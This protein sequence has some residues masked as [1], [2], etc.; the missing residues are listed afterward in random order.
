[1]SHPRH[2]EVVVLLALTAAI[3]CKPKAAASLHGSAHGAAVEAPKAIPSFNG[4]F[5]PMACDFAGPQTPRDVSGPDGSNSYKVEGLQ[6][7]T[8]TEGMRVCNV[9][10]HRFAEHR[11]QG[12]YD[13]DKGRDGWACRSADASSG[14]L[15]AAP[16]E[17]GGL[18]E[19][20]LVRDGDT[21]EVQ[22]AH[23]TCPQELIDEAIAAALEKDPMA[24]T[25]LAPCACP[26]AE[27]VFEARVFRISKD[28]G[29]DTLTNT[30]PPPTGE[31]ARYFGS[32]TGTL[33]DGKCSPIQS[34]WRVDRSCGELK[35]SAL[36]G[37]LQDPR[38][39]KRFNESRPH[40]VR[41][42]VTDPKLLSRLDPTP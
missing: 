34:G 29:L 33:Y 12:Q 16:G 23:T 31:L 42:L 3:S 38:G 7:T 25:G 13:V 4:S 14:D 30:P 39:A 17:D 2:G 40:G 10:F 9:R 21:V 18:D 22:W 27:I 15:Q 24:S 5:E 19:E 35:L 37:W 36:E 28:S 41:E 8:S 26:G 11:S 1:M 32:T 6:R 20:A